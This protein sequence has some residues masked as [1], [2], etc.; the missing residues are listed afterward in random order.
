MHVRACRCGLQRG[1][2]RTVGCHLRCAFHASTAPRDAF[3]TTQLSQVIHGL[4]GVK[5]DLQSVHTR[6]CSLRSKALKLLHYPL[7]R[8]QSSSL[9]PRCSLIAFRPGPTQHLP[10]VNRLHLS[11][12]IMAER[13]SS[14]SRSS[15]VKPDEKESEQLQAKNATA[16]KK[17]SSK[18]A[19]AEPVPPKSKGKGKRVAASTEA[20]EN[21]DVEPVGSEA[22]KKPEA[23]PAKRAKKASTSEEAGPSSAAAPT[24]AFQATHGDNISLATLPR[25]SISLLDDLSK[26]LALPFGSK[27]S[28]NKDVR[29]VAWNITSWNASIKKGLFRYLAYENADI[30]VLTETKLNAPP[31][32]PTPKLSFGGTPAETDATTGAAASAGSS[33][34][35][36]EARMWKLYPHR[37]NGIDGTRKGYAGIAVWSKLKPNKVTV[38]IPSFNGSNDSQ[39]AYDGRVITLEF[40]ETCVVGT[41]ATNAGEGL[42]KMADKQRWIER[43]YAYL[44]YLHSAA[45]G[46]KRIIWCGDL[47]VVIDERDL[48]MAKKKWNKHPGYTQIEC[49]AHRNFLLTGTAKGAQSEDTAQEPKSSTAASGVTPKGKFVDI[50]RDRNPDNVGQFSEWIGIDWVSKLPSLPWLTMRRCT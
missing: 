38:G 24:A 27:S 44:D 3:P 19:I 36:I 22:S 10:P 13:R 45:Y 39:G 42:G 28:N 5:L 29:I 25:D 34:E 15:P 12:I 7:L 48:S 33:L 14:R 43:F 30:V 1:K 18:A 40:D 46:N 49:D 50:W 47:N 21:E 6:M 16:T 31:E 9:S 17:S 35:E 20:E 26:P 41:Y 8:T 2:D 32:H 23:S 4:L 11:S 37:T